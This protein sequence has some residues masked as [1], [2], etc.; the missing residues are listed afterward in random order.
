VG[1][2]ARFQQGWIYFSKKV[3]GGSGRNIGRLF[4]RRENFQ[5][6]PDIIT[7]GVTGQFKGVFETHDPI[8]ADF[9]DPLAVWAFKTHFSPLAAV[10]QTLIYF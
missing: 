6:E 4:D 10:V 3:L 2:V 7:A 9:D 8:H 5:I 1:P